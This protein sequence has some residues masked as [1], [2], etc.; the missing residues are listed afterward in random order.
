MTRLVFIGVFLIWTIL[1]SVSDIRFRR[2]SNSLVL[3]GLCGGMGGAFLNANPF[4]VSP[5]QA[6]IG[7]LVALIVFFPLFLS[8]V[9]GAA[10]VKIFAVLGTWCGVYALLWLWV[11]AS[12]AAGVHVLVLILLADAPFGALWRRGTPAMALGGRRA[13]PYAAFLVLPA[14]AWLLHL[15]LVRGT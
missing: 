3:A 14:A 10:D 8:R 2:I 7:M 11:I 4:A 15:M 9:M 1:V 12:L 6:L 5:M 13:T